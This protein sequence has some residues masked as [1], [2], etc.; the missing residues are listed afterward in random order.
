MPIYSINGFVTIFLRYAPSCRPLLLL[1]DGHSSHYQ[2][3]VVEMAAAEQVSSF[4]SP[5]IQCT[6]LSLLIKGHLVPSN[7]T[8][9]K[10]AGSHMTMNSG[11]VVTR[12]SF[13]Q[14]FCKAYSRAFTIG[15]VTASFRDT[16]V[17]PFNRKVLLPPES[18]S[19]LAQRTGLAYI[20]LFSPRPQRAHAQGVSLAWI[21]HICNCNLKKLLEIY[22]IHSIICGCRYLHYTPLCSFLQCSLIETVIHTDACCC[23]PFIYRV[24]TAN[25]IA[26]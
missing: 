19:N 18:E 15:N 16:G 5:R 17:Y 10:P 7:C 20:P 4:A 14:L 25:S 21:K 3:A 23:I 12:Y 22:C 24:C 26:S 13:S 1:L 9:R 6:S 8:G 11:Q 2:P